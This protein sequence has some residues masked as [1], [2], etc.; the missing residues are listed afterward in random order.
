MI[1]EQ[2]KHIRLLPGE[3]T[4]AVIRQKFSKIGK[5]KDIS[6]EGL[7]IEYIVGENRNHKHKP[8]RVDI[9]MT[10]HVFHIYNVPCELIYDEEI[11]VPYVNNKYAKI[12]TVKRC[13]VKFGELPED[14]LAQLEL[15]FESYTTGLA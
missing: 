2:R 6:Q 7:A 4:F 5:V 12:L 11:H 8:T 15:F 3:N 1:V 9:F 13:G 10:E 14:N